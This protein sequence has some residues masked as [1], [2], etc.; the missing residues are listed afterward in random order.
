MG[1]AGFTF[2]CYHYRPDIRNYWFG[3]VALDILD[4]FVCTDCCNV[5][6]WEEVFQVKG[7]FLFGAIGWCQTNWLSDT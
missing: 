5:V 6:V 7:G 2:H 1:D 4:H 3:G